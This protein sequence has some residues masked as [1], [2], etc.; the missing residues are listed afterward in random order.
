MRSKIQ[1]IADH[2]R[3]HSLRVLSQVLDVSESG[4]YAWE[5]RPASSQEREDV[6]LS[7]VIQQIF[8]DHGQVYGSP[9]IHTVLAAQ[10]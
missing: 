2:H 3:E 7:A 5:M 4:Y 1:F 6:R 8:V 10:A 9:R